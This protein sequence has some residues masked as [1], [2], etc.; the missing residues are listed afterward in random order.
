MDS[1]ILP[2]N[3]GFGQKLS[4]VENKLGFLFFTQD[5]ALWAWMGH[6]LMATLAPI[7]PHSPPAL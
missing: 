3:K 6:Q 2:G 4:P 5:T 7:S 1:V